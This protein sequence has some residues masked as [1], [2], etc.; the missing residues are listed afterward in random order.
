MRSLEGYDSVHT[1]HQNWRLKDV[2]EPNDLR[3][4][5]AAAESDDVPSNGLIQ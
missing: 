1:R 3:T 2:Q 4:S 5:L